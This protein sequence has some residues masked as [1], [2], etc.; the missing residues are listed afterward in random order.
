M[1]DE[2]VAVY[3]RVLALRAKPR[4]QGHRPSNAR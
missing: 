2:Y 4:K 1:L 3:H